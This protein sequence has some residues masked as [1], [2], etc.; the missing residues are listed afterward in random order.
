MAADLLERMKLFDRIMRDSDA[1][2][3][4][5][6]AAWALLWGFYNRES[7]RC[8][9]S[10]ATI[11]AR[12]GA[13]HRH[14]RR[15]LQRLSQRGYFRIGVLQGGGSK[16]GPTNIYEPVF[17]AT[18]NPGQLRPPRAATP[19]VE[20]RVPVPSEGKN[21]PEPRAA[22][23]SKPSIEPRERAAPPSLPFS[24]NGFHGPMAVRTTSAVKKPA[25]DKSSYLA[26][27]GCTIDSYQP[28]P[29][30]MGAWA[31]EHALSQSRRD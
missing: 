12:A 24:A 14:T 2:P 9:P 27:H 29:V 22:T 13:D 15:A 10:A 19:L 17:D 5:R 16:H 28:D 26:K 20:P 21:S 1:T 30:T 18:D 31:A 23:P 4:E 3:V 25:R 11:A 6:A 7:G 8:D